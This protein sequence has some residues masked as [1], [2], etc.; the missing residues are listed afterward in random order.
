ME[1]ID[2]LRELLPSEIVDNFDI[3]RFEKTKERFDICQTQAAAH[4]G[5]Q[6][7]MP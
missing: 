1:I 4:A 7:R 5:D 2:L 6:C 3:V